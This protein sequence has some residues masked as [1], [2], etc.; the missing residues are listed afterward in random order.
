MNYRFKK[1]V[2]LKS[3]KTI[4]LLF[5]D[6]KQVKKFPLKLVFLPITFKEDVKHQVAFSV[7][8]RNFKK[9]VDRNRLKR[10]LRESYRLQ[11]HNIKLPK[12]QY[13][14]MFIYIGKEKITFEALQDK[15]EQLLLKFNIEINSYE[16][17]NI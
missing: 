15:M 10:L 12:E 9:A 16:K 6:G 3:R 2:H 17:E 1:E 14:L 4:R 7:P 8:K 5:E 11:Q 13:A